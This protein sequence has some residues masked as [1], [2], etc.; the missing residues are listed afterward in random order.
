MSDIDLV[1]RMITRGQRMAS[2]AIHT[3]WIV[4]RCCDKIIGSLVDTELPLAISER[5]VWLMQNVL[6]SF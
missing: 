3:D 5:P 4:G 2:S 6:L 1:E